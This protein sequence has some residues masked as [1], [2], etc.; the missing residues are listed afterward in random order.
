[1]RPFIDLRNKESIGGE[2]R[3]LNQ[4]QK[5]AKI[6]QN[7]TKS[8]KYSSEWKEILRFGLTNL[9]CLHQKESNI[10]A[11]DL[12]SSGLML[13]FLKLFGYVLNQNKIAPNE[14][15][16]KQDIATGIE[17]H[18]N[19]RED[20]IEATKII[21]KTCSR[22]RVSGGVSNSPGSNCNYQISRAGITP[23]C[24]PATIVMSGGVYS[25]TRYIS[26][27]VARGVEINT[28]GANYI[29]SEIHI[30]NQY[31]EEIKTLHI[32]TEKRIGE[33]DAGNL[34]L[35]EKLLGVEQVSDGK[36]HVAQLKD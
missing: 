30:L 19:D 35:L 34:Q 2:V 20:F 26:R 1:M 29:R 25:K 16:H 8:S 22:W 10:S 9:G 31:V 4:Y 27:V 32:T 14:P 24:I 36:L 21:K 5:E 33:M 12:G 7:T 23:K 3:I 15:R 11:Y 18:N 6:L 13:C 28:N 17:E